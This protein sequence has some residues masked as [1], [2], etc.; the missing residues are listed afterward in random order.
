MSYI[1]KNHFVR[2]EHMD[3]VGVQLGARYD[4]SPIIIG[5]DPPP[6]DRFP[7]MYDEYVPTGI[8][9]GRLPHLWL[10]DEREQGGSLFDRLGRGLTLLRLDPSL[11]VAAFEEAARKQSLPLMVLDLSLPEA[12]K[13]YGRA[14]ILVRPDQYI[15][16][17]ED[18]VPEDPAA[19]LAQVTGH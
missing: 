19:V 17:R 15:A 12:R 18:R 6:M 16:W 2:P 8:P 4:G 7:E 1:R 13:L 10:D 11:S 14:L 3:G 9:G 5:D